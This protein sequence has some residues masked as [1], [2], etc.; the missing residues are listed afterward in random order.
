VFALPTPG[1]AGPSEAAAVVMFGDLLPPADAIL[2][3]AV[4]R[5]ATF[6]LQVVI[7]VVFLAIATLGSAWQ[8]TRA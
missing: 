6:Y 3:V 1:G 8:D 5:V 4:F 7:G 2:V